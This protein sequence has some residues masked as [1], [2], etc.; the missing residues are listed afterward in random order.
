ME[1]ITAHGGYGN[2]EAVEI[3][4]EHAVNEADNCGEV[5]LH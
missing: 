1:K 2:N 4:F 5:P 3:G